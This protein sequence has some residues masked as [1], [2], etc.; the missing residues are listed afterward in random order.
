MKTTKI[1][2]I[3]TIITVAIIALCGIAT[4]SAE[5]P[6]FYPLLTVVVNVQPIGNDLCIVDCMDKEGNLWSFYAEPCEW[7]AGDLANLL[8]WATGENEEDDEVVEVYYE[9]FLEDAEI[10]WNLQ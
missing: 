3:A 5:R 1:A 10:S 4:A 9:G 7:F 6:E 8:M 2:I